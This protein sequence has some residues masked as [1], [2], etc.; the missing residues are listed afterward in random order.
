MNPSI[1]CRGLL[2]VIA[3][4]LAA[5]SAQAETIKFAMIVGNNR[6]HDASETLRYAELDARKVYNVLTEFGD[7]SPDRTELL[8][9][10]DAGSVRQAMERMKRKIND[11]SAKARA[12]ENISTLWVFYYSG[13]AEGDVLELKE[14]SLRWS[15]L[16]RLLKSSPA[17]V[18]I[19]FVD[20]CQSGRLISNKGGKPGTSYDIRVTDEIHSRGYAIITSSA[21]NE[22]SQESREIRGAFFTHYLI[23]GLR[24]AGDASRDGKVTLSEAY[25]YAY[26]RT[27]ARTSATIGGGQHAM[28]HFQLEGRGEIVLTQVDKSGS[29]LAITA[30]DRGR[31][32]LLDQWAQ[33]I[34]AEVELRSDQTELL[35]VRPGDYEA[36]LLTPKGAV[37][38]AEVHVENGQRAVLGPDDFQSTVLEVAVA[39]GGLFR[40][41]TWTHRLA[42]GGLWRL[43]PLAGR[44]AAYGGTAS[45]R[46]DHL[47]SWQ[48]LVVR[49][50]WTRAKDAGLSTGYND[51]AALVGAG[52]LVSHPWISLRVELLLGYEHLFQSRWE[53]QN[54]HSTGLGYLSLLS[55]EIPV[56]NLFISVES[57]IG[58]RVFK[59][60][61]K[62]IVHRI[63]FQA[64][65]CLGWKWSVER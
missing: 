10:A 5:R 46:L 13:H 16:N 56:E 17:D 45:Y 20:S 6:G 30:K 2:L 49:F 31:L 25:E 36:Y 55:L 29:H 60:R 23:S 22:L 61:D 1:L 15:E 27:L 24:G 34:V 59:V 62:G 51:L 50:S 35:A 53:G 39:K 26:A 11:I 9:G 7:F 38:Q 65:L 32:V 48:P 63:D 12:T 44:T 28:Y 52:Y 21:P 19:A 37:R 42:T 3:L 64:A 47:S 4:Q 8:L 58:G 41:A 57:G 14:S 40:R 54:R 43:F 33:T 18:R